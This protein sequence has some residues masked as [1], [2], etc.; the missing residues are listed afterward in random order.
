MNLTDEIKKWAEDGTKYGVIKWSEIPD[1]DLYMDQVLGFL[2]EKL[3]FFKRDE[4]TK[5][6]TSSMVNNYVKSDVIAHPVRKKYTKE[7]LSQ[8]IIICMLKQVLSIPDIKTLLQNTSDAKTVYESF[9]KKQTEAMEEV[10][11]QIKASVDSGDDIKAVA[12]RFAAEANAKRAAAERI[13]VELS[14]EE[15]E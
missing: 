6:I 15:H 10:N 7:Q 9:E 12:L 2:G 13:L 11:E 3:E 4:D 8:L 5:L 14:K 1:I